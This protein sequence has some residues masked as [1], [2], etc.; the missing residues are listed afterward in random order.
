MQAGTPHRAFRAL[1]FCLLSLIGACL[2]PSWAWA[3]GRYIVTP[4][5]SGDFP[6]LRAAVCGAEPGAVILL[7]DGTYCGDGNRDIVLGE[8]P[9]AIGS[10][11]G[12]PQR[13]VL[14]CAGSAALPHRA[15]LFQG[16][17]AGAV[18]VF[19]LTITGG[20]ADSGGGVLCEGASP[21][22]ES[23][24]FTDNRA[25]FVGGAVACQHGACPRL[26][27]CLL[28]RNHSDS[29]GGGVACNDAY[30]TFE[31]CALLDNT[32]GG[33][34]GG[35]Y[36]TLGTL[37]E[38]TLQEQEAKRFRPEIGQQAVLQD[39]VIAG[40][41]AD[42]SGGA[43]RLT[44]C[45]PLLE[46]TTIAFNR[47]GG[48]V[49]HNSFSYPEFVACCFYGNGEAE[50]S[51]CLLD[52][53]GI[54]GN[55][56]VHPG[57]L[58]DRLPACRWAMS[59][60]AGEGSANLAAMLNGK[61]FAEEDQRPMGDW[62]DAQQR[63][64]R[65]RL[66]EIRREIIQLRNSGWFSEIR[67]DYVTA[68]VLFRELAA[69]LR[70]TVDGDALQIATAWESLAYLL[71]ERGNDAEAEELYSEARL[72]R[73]RVGGESALGVGTN[74]TE[75]ADLASEMG[76]TAR[77]ESLLTC[78]LEIQR[79][80]P[81]VEVWEL[82]Q[83]LRDLGQ[84]LLDAGDAAA[85]ERAAREALEIHLFW[86]HGRSGF[87]P[88]AATRSLLA[89]AL[90]AQGRHE[91]AAAQQALVIGKRRERF[92]DQHPIMV[93]SYATEGDIRFDE[94]QPAAA[95][96][97]YARAA[98]VYEQVRE[99]VAVGLSRAVAMESPH[100]RH[101]A[102]LLALGR[103]DEAWPVLEAGRGRAIA[104]LTWAG[105]DV[106]LS[107]GDAA[108]EDSLRHRLNRCEDT[109]R[110]LEA[111]GAEGAA[112]R[113]TTA[114]REAYVQLQE[115]GAAWAT[116]Q[117]E[118]SARYPPTRGQSYPLER[119]QAALAEHAA[120]IGWLHV[121]VGRPEQRT[122]GFVIRSRGPVHWVP[123]PRAAAQDGGSRP[124]ADQLRE[125]L[126]AEGSQTQRAEALE[127]VA[128]CAH[129]CW[130][131]WLA[132]LMPELAGV[133]QLIVVPSGP[134]LDVPLEVCVDAE[135]AYVGSRY[136]VSYA[137]SATLYAWLVEQARL[138]PEPSTRRALL[139]GDPP[140]CARHLAAMV[141]AAGPAAWDGGADDPSA[142]G[143]SQPAYSESFV[144]NALGGNEKALNSLQRLPW[145]AVEI[146]R[147]RVLLPDATTLVGPD[148]SEQSLCD[149]AR[150]GALKDFDTIHLATHALVSNE[151]PERSALVLARVG[152]PDPLQA[153]LRGER[154]YDGLLSV[155]EIVRDFDLDAD[156]VTLSACRTALG[157]ASGSE[158]YL[159]L[160]TAF[161]AAGA[162]SLL[163]SLWR[164]DDEATAQL[165]ARFYENL[166]GR[167][168]AGSDRLPAPPMS[169]AR[170]LQE[171]KQWLSGCTDGEGHRLFAHPS[172]WAGFVLVGAPG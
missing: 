133:E 114:E 82:A 60:P 9:L 73:L 169:K 55:R 8:K 124:V 66:W 58:A 93:E 134:M 7:A 80:A 148:A 19:G 89:R 22:I 75:L 168:R 21:A 108:R 155:S 34:G 44:Y 14:A 69:L 6:D 10:L 158:G 52:Q 106:R 79:S 109:A 99:Q 138:R 40:N 98:E 85:A 156:L 31:R 142:G 151:C 97:L 49:A 67:G 91:E 126:M 127:D 125:V 153:A 56:C 171:A 119:I 30:P 165:M 96:T 1:W 51:Q 152:L 100:E 35:F 63:E 131:Q 143:D 130:Q 146:D 76:Q 68:E 33:C 112:G 166:T 159:G 17:A 11:S 37:G 147:L 61:I 149:L 105:R 132:P 170:A 64:N 42:I 32:S 48:G 41:A 135:G 5:R 74:L 81:G 2:C 115:A 70:R 95:E 150:T 29:G 54:N 16:D 86:E 84:V 103:A 113:S 104:D 160:S 47:T 12:D 164:V 137:P 121:D 107:T 27:D 59:A 71:H 39:C 117:G 157:R 87:T 38:G 46:R 18:R 94:G 72:M 128:S 118:L 77:A 123:L 43:L 144:R 28:Y 116:L 23:C 139:V 163:V 101:A 65:R 78:A 90:E 136:A 62:A 15:F 50:T 162:R 25:G 13:C 122:A 3:A 145:T 120:L 24:I 161:L 45:S 36:A 167:R 92:G 20:Y 102:A 88:M 154:V 57:V 111:A 140:F 83:T 129:R 110:A 172:Y 26:R 53:I 141:A 4:D